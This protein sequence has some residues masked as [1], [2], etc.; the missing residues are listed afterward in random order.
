MKMYSVLLMRMS[1]IIWPT[2][3][4]R[5]QDGGH[6]NPECPGWQENNL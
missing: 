6:L 4:E 3:E 2:F 1:D 5:F